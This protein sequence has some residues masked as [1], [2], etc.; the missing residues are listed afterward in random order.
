M[1]PLYVLD[2]LSTKKLILIS[3][4]HMLSLLIEIQK[5][6]LGIKKIKIHYPK[7]SVMHE[8]EHTIS[9][10]FNDVSKIPVL[11]QIITAHKEK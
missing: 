3:Q 1:E 10:F 4:S 5:Y 2:L 11:N 9:L 8:V 7:V 6:S